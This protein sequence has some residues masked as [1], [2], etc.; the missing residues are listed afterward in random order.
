M[1]PLI[2]DLAALCLLLDYSLVVP[3]VK[4]FC[5]FPGVK[6]AKVNGQKTGRGPSLSCRTVGAAVLFT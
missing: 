6:S 3:L 1:Q 4:S 2:R 5:S